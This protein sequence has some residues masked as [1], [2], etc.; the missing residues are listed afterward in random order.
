MRLQTVCYAPNLS[1]KAVCVLFFSLLLVTLSA[2]AMQE[3][4]M[5]KV[6]VTSTI[7]DQEKVC[8]LVLSPYAQVKALKEEAASILGTAEFV[9]LYVIYKSPLT[10]YMIDHI[11][12]PLSDLDFVHAIL[13]EYGSSAFKM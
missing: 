1:L 2:H 7:N 3:N 10:L 6:K 13:Q 12:K 4:R 8:H 11:S 5:L 9:P